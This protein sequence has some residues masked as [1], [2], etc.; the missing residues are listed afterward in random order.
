MKW[1]ESNWSKR[2][3]SKLKW[4]EIEIK[5]DPNDRIENWIKSKFIFESKLSKSL[6]SKSKFLKILIKFYPM[7]NISK[8]KLMEIIRTIEIKIE[9]YQLKF[10][11]PYQKKTK[12]KFSPTV[13]QWNPVYLIRVYSLKLKHLIR[14]GYDSDKLWLNRQ[15]T[16]TYSKQETNPSNISKDLSVFIIFEPFSKLNNSIALQLLKFIGGL[17][18]SR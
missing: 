16:S 9:I 17:M 2:L 6:M 18:N 12:F 3:K 11:P 8:L 5:I 15:P 1:I 4:I 10:I 7:I 13:A 14:G